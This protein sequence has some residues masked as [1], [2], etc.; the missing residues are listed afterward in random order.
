MNITDYIST[1]TTETPCDFSEYFYNGWGEEITECR[2]EILYWVDYDN[3]TTHYDTLK[4]LDES[5]DEAYD[6]HETLASIIGWEQDQEWMDDEMKLWRKSQRINWWHQLCDEAV[7]HWLEEKGVTYDDNDLTLLHELSLFL[8][9]FQNG[10]GYSNDTTT[11]ALTELSSQRLS[12][13]NT[14]CAS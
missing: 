11:R 14:M 9:H 3:N 1:L 5:S 13:M 6:Y 12:T 7:T 2:A 4:E 8:H 10:Y